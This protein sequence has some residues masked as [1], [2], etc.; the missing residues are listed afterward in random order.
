MNLS[1]SRFALSVIAFCN[2]YFSN[3]L[4][5]FLRIPHPNEEDDIGVG[6]NMTETSEDETVT[7]VVRGL[8]LAG[9]AA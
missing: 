7:E 8:R 6:S 2:D 5:I 4:D 3:C 9:C 1:S